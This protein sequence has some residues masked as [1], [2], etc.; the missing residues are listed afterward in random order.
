MRK[1]WFPLIVTALTGA[2]VACSDGAPE[3]SE[4][5]ED[6]PVPVAESPVAMPEPAPASIATEYAPELNVDL[7]G[8]VETPTGLR[9][10]DV[11]AG[12]GATAASGNTVSVHYTGW[13]P[14]GTQFDSSRDGGEPFEFVL[15]EGRV[16]PGWDQGVAGMQ[17]GGTRRLVIP[18]DLAY[19]EAGAPGAIPPNAT[20][21]F[22]VEL[23]AVR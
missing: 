23:L 5:S 19:G 6:V 9:Y 18:P 1:M 22:D 21:V 16:I 12:S 8:M 14:D 13:L 20:L 11:T 17:V 10:E 15:G 3:D 7:T 4:D 2:F